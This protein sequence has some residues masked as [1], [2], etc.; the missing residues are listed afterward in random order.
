MVRRFVPTC[1]VLALGSSVALADPPVAEQQYGWKREVVRVDP[2]P[3]EQQHAIISQIMYLNRCVGG[4]DLK[5]GADDDASTTVP[6]SA[7][8]DADSHLSQFVH[9]DTVWNDF[10]TC[11][12][13]IYS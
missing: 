2:K 4:C 7:L 11:M 13:E 6:T 10:V 1:L 5:A 12:K 8:I 9:S 3:G